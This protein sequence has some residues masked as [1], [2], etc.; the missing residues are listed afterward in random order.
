M[1]HAGRLSIVLNFQVVD[2]SSTLG[3]LGFV[4]LDKKIINDFSFFRIQ[5]YRFRYLSSNSITGQRAIKT[6]PKLFDCIAKHL[7]NER[8]LVSLK[9]I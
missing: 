8:A 6:G 1:T 2:P 9:S 3:P 4:F 7:K 5:I